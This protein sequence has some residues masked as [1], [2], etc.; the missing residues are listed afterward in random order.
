MTPAPA[1]LRRGRG[2]FCA[3]LLLALVFRALAPSERPLEALAHDLLL[4]TGSWLLARTWFSS[5]ASAFFVAVASM[6]SEGPAASALP[7]LLWLLLGALE[8]GDRT[9]AFLAPILAG[10][11][12]LAN[13]AG[14]ALVAPVSAALILAALAGQGRRPDWRRLALPAVLGLLA[15]LP[16]FVFALRDAGPEGGFLKRF[17][18]ATT[19]ENPS[20]LLN[21]LFGLSPHPGFPLFAGS[22]T[23]ALALAAVTGMEGRALRRL[24]WFVPVAIALLG[25]AVALV[26][27]PPLPSGT[28]PLRLLV[29]FLAGLGLDRLL[30]AGD[31]RP[32]RI[33]GAVTGAAAVGVAALSFAAD[34]SLPAVDG[35]LLRCAGPDLPW[36]AE[37]LAVSALGA[38][39]ASATLLL[40]TSVPRAAPLAL[41]LLLVLHPL[42]VSGWKFRDARLRRPPAIEA[43]VP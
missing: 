3:A 27:G 22:F 21:V 32:A 9:K 38:A 25:A 2:L 40:R 35:L 26:P 36:T 24:L 12:A 29:V 19:L 37:I 18:A 20:Q 8:K 13:P 34:F 11:Q 5:P 28:A 10:A 23:A 16:A 15:A 39:A 41:A 30:A 4:L 43:R 42:D 6:S 1:D 17:F 7:L 31:P 14:T 33:A